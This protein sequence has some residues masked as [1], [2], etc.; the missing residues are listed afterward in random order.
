[1]QSETEQKIRVLYREAFA[2]RKQIV[3]AFVVLVGIALALGLSWPKAYTSSTTI[4]VE[5]QNIIEPLMQ[6]AAVRSGMIDQARNASEII[7][8]RSMLLKVL[9][10]GGYLSG[11]PEPAEI[12]SMI[13]GLKEA[14]TISNVG[15]NLIKIEYKGNDPERVYETTEKLAELFIEEMLAARAKESNAAY[16]FIDDQVRKY[17]KELLASEE[18]LKALRQ[19]HAEARPGAE[20]E[21]NERITSLR[22]SIDGIEQQLREG[23]IRVA[24][25][26][27]QL[28]GEV[29][30]ASVMSRE[31]EYRSRI[32]ELRNRLDTLRLSYHDSYPDI[33][34]VKEQIKELEQAVSK[35][36]ARV[37]RARQDAAASGQRYVDDTLRNNP[38]YQQLQSDL[39]NARTN[40]RTLQARLADTQ[41][42]LQE[43]MKRAQRIQEVEAQFQK[44]TRDY[45][46]NQTIYQDLL[47][48]RE[49]A[50][51]SMNLNSE[52]QGLTLRV[53]EPAYFSHQPSGPRLMHFALGGLILGA[54][55]PLGVLFGFLTL[56]PRVRTPA[57]ISHQMGLPMLTVIPHMDTPQEAAAERRGL[58]LSGLVVLLTVAAVVAVLLLRVQGKI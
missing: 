44:L 37:A 23:E 34:I 33:V 41:A 16:E 54:A 57:S 14:T 9:E 5:Q 15:Q 58:L 24:S 46:V 27:D 13:E 30:V 53:V 47:R 55:L 4:Q 35:E 6:G 7:Y 48:R 12:E 3:A 51:V 43:E 10:Q 36:A 20:R 29:Q 45:Q 1:M 21:T 56:D 26:E 49:N 8:G 18:R 42:K 39:Y 50:R 2:H 31:Q 52:Q 19:E 32:N 28:S 40:V 25:L 22:S 17:E 11:N 38:V